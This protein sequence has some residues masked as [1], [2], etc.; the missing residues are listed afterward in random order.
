MFWR[1][2]TTP[3]GENSKLIFGRLHIFTACSGL[4]LDKNS[5]RG[6]SVPIPCFP[7]Y[8][9]LFIFKPFLTKQ[10]FI[11]FMFVLLLLFQNI[12]LLDDVCNVVAFFCCWP[13]LIIFKKPSL[14]LGSR[15]G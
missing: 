7:L 13:F 1:S 2:R 14:I 11:I 12:G 3:P 8:W 4:V 10:L 5:T 9:P 15:L 6:I